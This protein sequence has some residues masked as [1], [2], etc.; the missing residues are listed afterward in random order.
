LR[1]WLVDS[2]PGL[3]DA[4]NT[5][6]VVLARASRMS[7]EPATP[8]E[9]LREDAGRQGYQV[10]DIGDVDPVDISLLIEVSAR[11][12]S[13]MFLPKPKTDSM[14]SVGR[15][16]SLSAEPPLFPGCHLSVRPGPRRQ[17]PAT[18]AHADSSTTPEYKTY[19]RQVRSVSASL[20]SSTRFPQH[21]P[22][23][24]PGRR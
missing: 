22:V 11:A 7:R 1:R 19:E 3:S 18:V 6:E 15:T 13:M 9:R 8:N 21:E 10:V 14:G 12:S 16:C 24:M 4:T 23:A 2:F 20:L 17:P 5:A